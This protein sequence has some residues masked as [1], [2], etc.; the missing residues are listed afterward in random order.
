MLCAAGSY[1]GFLNVIFVLFNSTWKD[2]IIMK[3]YNKPEFFVTYLTNFDV[4]TVSDI[5]IEDPDWFN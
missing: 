1:A 2:D 3:K 4:I 5:Y